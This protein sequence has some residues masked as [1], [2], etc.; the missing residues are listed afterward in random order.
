MKVEAGKFTNYFLG[1]A[2]SASPSPP[3]VLHREG[4]LELCHNWGTESDDTFAGYHNGNKPPQGFGHIALTCDDVNKTCAYLEDKNV[5][6]QKK[7]S[8]GSMKE[9]GEL[10]LL[11]VMQDNNFHKAL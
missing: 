2:D 1:F 5:T 11:L 4:V 10:L 7:L 6:F 9:I 3:G 8:E